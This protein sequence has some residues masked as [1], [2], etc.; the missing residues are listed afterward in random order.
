MEDL[1]FGV[2]LEDVVEYKS[3][4][5]QQRT[6]LF[7]GRQKKPSI[8]KQLAPKGTLV[9]AVSS[10]ETEVNYKTMLGS[11][12]CLSCKSRQVHKITLQQKNLLE[13][14]KRL[15]DRTEVLQKLNWVQ[16]LQ[17]GSLVFVTV[18]T[19]PLPVQGVVRYIGELPGET[20]TNFG[21]EFL[22][23]KR[24]RDK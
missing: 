21:V 1:R 9:E 7:P 23:K 6:T 3:E 17:V 14:V 11:S 12:F 10:R 15:H 5:R 18:P 20:G 2:L 19:I 13:G 22:E 4:V 24:R 16:K 8:T